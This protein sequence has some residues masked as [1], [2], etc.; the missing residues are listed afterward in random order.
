MTGCWILCLTI[1]AWCLRLCVM[2][3]PWLKRQFDHSCS[4]IQSMELPTGSHHF[5]DCRCLGDLDFLPWRSIMTIKFRTIFLPLLSCLWLFWD[6]SIILLWPV[7]HGACLYSL[8]T[9]CSTGGVLPSS[10]LI[11]AAS[12]EGSTPVSV[13]PTKVE[14]VANLIQKLVLAPDI[15]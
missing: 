3:L 5:L 11:G 4:F 7:D 12:V 2:I 6:C 15:S 8:T 1:L 9:W 10:A 14:V 13:L